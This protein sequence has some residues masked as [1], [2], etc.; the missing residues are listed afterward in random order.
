MSQTTITTSLL[1]GLLNDDEIAI[2]SL[3]T[4]FYVLTTGQK[5][6]DETTIELTELFRLLREGRVAALYL[7]R[8]PRSFEG[9]Y[10]QII[11][12]TDAVTIFPH[13][14]AYVEADAST[15]NV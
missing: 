1:I 9:T 5:T 12:L 2:E 7:P 15:V 11:E 13:G 3:R 8:Y 4:E 14:I 10:G 6:Y